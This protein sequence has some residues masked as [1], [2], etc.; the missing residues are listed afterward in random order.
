MIFNFFLNKNTD[1]KPNYIMF[2]FYRLVVS[3]QHNDLFNWNLQKSNFV[4]D[5]GKPKW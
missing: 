2:S 3:N 4:L 1:V 5:K